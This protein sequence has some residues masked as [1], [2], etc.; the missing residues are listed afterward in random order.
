VPVYYKQ[1]V[2]TKRNWPLQ[3]S[4]DPHKGC[5][6][7]PEAPGRYQLK[8][9]G[10]Q[11]LPEI[12]SRSSMAASSSRFQ[13]LA[14]A[15]RCWS[16]P[17]RS[18][19]HDGSRRH[20]LARGKGA[21]VA[22][23]YASILHVILSATGGSLDSA[24]IGAFGHAIRPTWEQS[25]GAGGVHGWRAGIFYATLEDRLPADMRSRVCELLDCWNRAVAWATPRG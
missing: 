21:D 9:A 6:G 17:G 16:L 24:G 2:M 3:N 25:A 8:V 7:D 23:K 22:G 5:L 4:R 10:V 14:Q 13:S 20:T 12:R 11:T 18:P 15:L 1:N 19:A